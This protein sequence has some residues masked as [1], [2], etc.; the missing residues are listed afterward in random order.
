VTVGPDAFNV[1][2]SSLQVTDIY[3]GLPTYK[4]SIDGVANM[5]AYYYIDF[6]SNET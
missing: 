1:T 5:D 3:P 2:A 4:A 6:N